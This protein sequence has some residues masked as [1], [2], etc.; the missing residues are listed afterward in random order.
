MKK[1]ILLFVLSAA[2]LRTLAQDTAIV[3]TTKHWKIHGENTLLISQSSFS[4]WSAG[5]VNLFSGNVLLNY[6]FNYKKDK[7]TWDSKAIIG[8]GLSSHP[9]LGVRKT[10]DRIILNSLLGYQAAKYWLYTFYGNF[11]TQFTHGYDYDENGRTLISNAF[12]P[13]YFTF[14]PGIAYKQSNS[15][16]VNLSP[17]ASRIILMHDDYLSSIG[18]FGVRPGNRSLYQFGASL[19]AFYEFYVAE[20]I[21]L[22]NN[23]KLYSDY[24]DAPQNIYTDLTSTL[25]MKVNSFITVNASIQM[26][27][28]DRTDIP[29]LNNGVKGYKTAIQ[30][31]QI[32]GAGFTYKF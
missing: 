3:D 12:A 26:I 14:G 24:L 2:G 22:E 13:A 18:A 6:D 21:C 31:K 32:F 5:G 10:D 1:F 8:Y 11:Q 30:I 25:S 9:A 28:D 19:D 29:Y 27:Y 16:R 15:F 7:W 4:N 20:N 17:A 23:L